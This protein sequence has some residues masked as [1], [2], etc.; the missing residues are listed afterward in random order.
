MKLR[1]SFGSRS[2]HLRKEVFHVKCK[3]IQK[4]CEIVNDHIILLLQIICVALCGGQSLYSD[5][6][7]SECYLSLLRC[8]S[9]VLLPTELQ[10]TLSDIIPLC[11]SLCNPKKRKLF[12][13]QTK[14]DKMVTVLL[15]FSYLQSTVTRFHDSR[16]GLR[17]FEI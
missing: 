14:L 16:C 15:I 1:I 10:I 11:L 4:F 2:A 13:Y 7:L 5:T 17:A 9:D 12:M 3:T 8:L 6:Q